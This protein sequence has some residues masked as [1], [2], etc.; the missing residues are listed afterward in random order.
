MDAIK[1]TG[2]VKKIG[3]V[4]EK[5]N[6]KKQDL[7]I[8]TG[9][10]YSQ[11]YAIEFFKEKTELLEFLSEGDKVTIS[12]NLRGREWKNPQDEIKYFLSLNGWKID[13]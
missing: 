4:V 10:E 5:S 8:E 2:T 9:G 11:V 6:F 13:N 7:I 12:C 3:S 1:V